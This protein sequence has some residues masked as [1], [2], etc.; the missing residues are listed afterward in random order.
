VADADADLDV[1]E[2]VVDGGSL[3]MNFAVTDVTGESASGWD[4]FQFPPETTLE[5]HVRVT[6]SARNTTTET[7]SVTL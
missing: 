5:V 1:V 6:D 7:Q 2:V 4:L 3:N